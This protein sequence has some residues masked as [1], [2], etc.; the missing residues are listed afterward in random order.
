[1]EIQMSNVKV[2]PRW[3]IEDFNADNKFD[4]LAKETRSRGFDTEVVKYVPFEGGDYSRFYKG[5]D[6]VV[7]QASINLCK[8]FQKEARWIP[9]PWLNSKAYECSKYYSFLGRFHVNSDYV[10]LPRAEV[11]R[12]MGF[13]KKT[14]GSEDNALFL[15]P[16]SG[17]KTFTGKVFHERNFESD[18]DWVEEFT[19]P[20]S[21]III[22]SPKVIVREWRFIVSGSTVVTGSLYR[23]RIG[24]IGS[25]KYREIDPSTY[26]A[27]KKALDKAIE[28]ADEKYNPDP[29]YVI[30]ICETEK[31]EMNL[32]EVGSFSCAGLYDCNIPIIVD[33]AEKNALKEYENIYGSLEYDD[34]QRIQV[35]CTPPLNK[36]QSKAFIQS[37]I[38]NEGKKEPKE[39]RDAGK[40]V[41]EILRNNS[42]DGF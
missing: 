23:E 27:D 3:L 30:D 22:S 40:R 2:K 39:N 34:T 9:G 41:Y 17:H 42:K 32:L 26:P 16:S 25:G 28:I 21:L 15:R 29:M 10:M 18:W 33:E 5:H 1:M 8:Q 38:D 20:D 12:Q 37:M 7:V 31:G 19:D 24:P 35:R 36:E 13:L 4:K 11:P 14:F 6:C